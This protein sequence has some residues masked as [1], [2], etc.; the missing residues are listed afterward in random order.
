MQIK[1]INFFFFYYFNFIQDYIEKFATCWNKKYSKEDYE[2]ATMAVVK[3]YGQMRP[4][5]RKFNIPLSTLATSVK[6]AKLL[7]GN[8]KNQIKKNS[9]IKTE[10]HDLSKS[11]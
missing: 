3:G 2:G 9:K 8:K 5:S 10:F 11:P 6:R 7:L 4:L 1:K